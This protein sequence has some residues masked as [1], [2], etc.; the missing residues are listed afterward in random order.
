[1]NPID[2]A[3]SLSET[4][5][6]YGG[7]FGAVVT[8]GDEIIGDGF[9]IMLSRRDPTAHAAIMAIREASRYLKS[10]DL[11]CCEIHLSCEA[12][13]MCVSAI[14]L[15][16]IRKVHYAATRGDAA[17][18]GFGYPG[19]LVIPPDD[20]EFIQTSESEQTAARAVFNALQPQSEE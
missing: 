1:M 9:H 20:I 4:G 7:P 11:G 15:A 3:I 19:L 12:C 16:G 5:L 8:R 6:R 2:K 14:Y 10:S 18:F 17:R 13:P